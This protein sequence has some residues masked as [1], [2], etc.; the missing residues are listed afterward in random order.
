MTPD[1][2]E[3]CVFA[4]KRGDIENREIYCNS[5]YPF[6]ISVIEKYK[7]SP[8]Y[9]GKMS[10]FL[11]INPKTDCSMLTEKTEV[12]FIPMPNVQEKSNMVSYNIVPFEKV[13][14]GFTVFKRGDL[15]WAKITP[16]MQNGK[17]CIVDEMPTEIGFGSTEFHV[18][19]KRNNNVYMPFVWAVFS[20]EN[21]LKAAQA[22]F[23][24]SAGQ[25]RVSASFLENFPCV[26]PKYDKQVALASKFEH[27]LSN[28]KNKNAQALKLLNDF[29]K[30]ISNYL[31]LHRSTENEL[32]FA[33]R[34]KDLDGVIDVKRYTSIG[35]IDSVFTVMDVCDIVDEKVNVAQWGRE[36]VDWIRIDDLPNQ[37]LDIEMVRTQS[38]SEIKGTFFE[39]QKDDILVARLGPTILNQKIVM[40]RN[41]E[42]KTIASTE[43]LVLR[44]KSGYAPEAVMAVLKTTYYRDLMYS[45]ARGSTP[46]RYRLNKEDMLKLPFP[47]IR[48]RQDQIVNEANAVR[49]QVKI[50][51]SEAEYEWMRAK[52][53]FEKE[54]LEN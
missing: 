5:L 42:R 33:I 46:S 48:S 28:R 25:Q 10:D 31:G 51:R 32:C 24:G 16:C 26:I 49:K 22:V 36:V 14:K 12:S 21:V 23:S 15:I 13:K 41:P 29:G 9:C 19:R 50:M 44:V 30:S 27:T 45:H 34:L 47:D 17:S 43:F 6:Y 40:V 4:I 54:L 37:P 3:L 2:N 38:A 35:K 53:Q 8:Y 20:N 7:N 1:A 11:E 52:A 39:V 18:I